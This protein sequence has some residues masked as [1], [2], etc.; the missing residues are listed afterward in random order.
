VLEELPSRELADVAGT[1]DDRVLEVERT[2][3]RCGAGN[4]PPDRYEHDRKEP[5]GDKSRNVVR[6][7]HGPC[8]HKVEPRAQRYEMK[9]A[10]ELVNRGM[11][12]V[13]FVTLIKAVELGRNDPH[14][15][16]QEQQPELDAGARVS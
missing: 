5:E 1:D 2:P 11:V 4:A 14:R 10:D 6:D 7:P 12:N 3:S 9:D 16:R 8:R 15:D 13:L